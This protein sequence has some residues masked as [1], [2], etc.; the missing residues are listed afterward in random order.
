MSAIRVA[1]G[2]DRGSHPRQDLSGLLHPLPGYMRIGIARTEERGRALKISFM[3]QVRALR[4]EE[5]AGEG[6]QPAVSPRM[7]G[8]EFGRQAGS[9][10]EAANY[11]PLGWDPSIV[12]RP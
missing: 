8:H 11:D 2:R 1:P 10:G 9:L 12:R 6:D 3:C 4:A 7:S 5:T